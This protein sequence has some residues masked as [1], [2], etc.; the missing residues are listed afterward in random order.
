MLLLKPYV[1]FIH[2][3]AFFFFRG[4]KNV[5]QISIQESD[6]GI[7]RRLAFNGFSNIGELRIINNKVDAIESLTVEEESNVDGVIVKGNHFLNIKE[8][9]D[10]L[11]IRANERTVIVENFFPCNCQLHWIV[12]SPSAKTA[13]LFNLHNYCVSPYALH[14]QSIDVVN[15]TTLEM[16]PNPLEL[17]GAG[18]LKTMTSGYPVSYGDQN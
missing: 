12:S 10:V 9:E 7:L 15:L 16:C 13:P 18:P 1:F 8:S 2:S 11:K 17:Q 14:G 4:L 3:F 6:L 5:T